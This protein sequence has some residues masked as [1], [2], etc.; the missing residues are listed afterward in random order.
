MNDNEYG[1]SNQQN[2]GSQQQYN[3][4]L[5]EG[6]KESLPDGLMEKLPGGI[7]EK[8]ESA[9][10]EAAERERN[11]SAYE[12]VEPETFKI[13]MNPKLGIAA[14][15]VGFGGTI[16]FVKISPGMSV[17]CLGLMTLIFGIGAVVDKK[18]SF[19][20]HATNLVFPLFG[21][22]FMMFGVFL[23]LQKSVPMLSEG[24][25][26]GVVLGISFAVF[27]SLT[28]V[29]WFLSYRYKRKVCT[30]QVQ[31]RCVYVKE[32]KSVKDGHTYY[33]HAPVFEFCFRG[34]TYNIAENYSSAKKPLVGDICEIHINPNEP[35]EFY[36]Q[37]PKPI[38]FI[39]V[40]C[41][42]IVAIVCF[43]IF[44]RSS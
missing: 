9:L 32:K 5:I 24:N 16:L 33:E 42:M 22:M 20:K 17:I 3:S 34:N 25:Y 27:F 1:G 10:S 35:T 14:V 44:G 39:V 40:A 38:L 37:K 26:L 13:E 28:L 8:I 6:I 18:F 4:D 29:L 23:L 12:Y 31:A 30:E 36:R 11:K 15:I 2:I 7:S 43:A 41:I 19:P 21:L